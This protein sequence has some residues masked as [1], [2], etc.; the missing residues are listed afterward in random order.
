[1]RKN[2]TLLDL[3]LYDQ[4]LALM[5][6]DPTHEDAGPSQLVLK[7]IMNYSRALAV[8]KSRLAGTYGI[9]LN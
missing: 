5:D 1:M 7:N 3:N 2:F 8:V 4:E 6:E 9:L